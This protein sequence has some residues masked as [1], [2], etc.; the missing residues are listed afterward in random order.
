MKTVYRGAVDLKDIPAINKFV[1]ETAVQLGGSDETNGELI[2]ALHE[3]IAN[4]IIHGYQKQ[5]GFVEI[6][7]VRQQADLLVYVRDQAPLFDPT[8]RATPDITA[9][10]ERRLLGGMGIHMMRH[11]VDELRYSVNESGQ[12]E[13]LLIKKTP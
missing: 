8:T 2:V 7:V 10:L 6:E 13:L 1:T 11:F 5:P 9:P 3:A 4:I 12:N